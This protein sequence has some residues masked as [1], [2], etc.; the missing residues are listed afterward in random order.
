MQNLSEPEL[1]KLA[2]CGDQDAFAALQT[3]LESP[4][5]RFIWRLIGTQDAEDDIVQDSFI[6]L[7]LNLDRIQP[8]EN[9]RPYLF[10]IVRNR[11]YDLLRRKGRFEYMSLDEEPVETW[12]SLNEAPMTGSQPEEVTH[13]LLIQLEV[14]QAM[15]RLPEL[16]RQ[17]LILYSEES[18]SY[19]EIAE[20]MNCSIGTVKSRLFY[21]K[22]TLR[23]LISPETLQLLEAEFQSGEEA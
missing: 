15:E 19:Q 5:R 8:V 7:Y 3:R 12:V 14:Q 18:L 20:A 22:K 11:C 1:L 2:Q 13:W 17:T 21:A 4:M 9:L 16:Q 10:R 6:A 23:Q